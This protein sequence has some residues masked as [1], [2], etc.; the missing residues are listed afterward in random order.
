MPVHITSKCALSVR[1]LEL[2]ST[3]S[4]AFERLNEG[5]AVNGTSPAGEYKPAGLYQGTTICDAE[6]SNG[7]TE[8]CKGD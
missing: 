1:S 3:R 7:V 2:K 8:C 6:S 4:V 5:K